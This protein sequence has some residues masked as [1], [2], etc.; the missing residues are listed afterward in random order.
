MATP[1][2]AETT[3]KITHDVQVRGLTVQSDVPLRLTGLFNALFEDCTF[4]ADGTRSG[5]NGGMSPNT[6]RDVTFNRCVFKFFNGLNFWELPERSSFYINFTD[7]KFTGTNST[8]GEYASHWVLEGNS[9][10][11][12]PVPG[13]SIGIGL[14][15][16]DCAFVDNNVRCAAITGAGGAVIADNFGLSYQDNQ[17]VKIIGNTIISN[18]SNMIQCG[19]PD[20]IVAN[21]N[22][23]GGY[24]YL[25]VTASKNIISGNYID[26]DV[27]AL[28]I[29]CHSS[30]PANM[31]IT[32]NTII[33]P[34]SV[35][36]TCIQVDNP[37]GTTGK[38]TIAD[39]VIIGFT[40]PIIAP[41]SE[42][43]NFQL[44]NQS[45]NR[46]SSQLQL[47]VDPT[48]DWQISTAGK[49][50]TALASGVIVLGNGQGLM[51]ISDDTS[52]MAIFLMSAGGAVIKIAGDATYVVGAPGAGQVGI[53]YNGSR[54]TVTNGYV[55][56]RIFS[57]MLFRP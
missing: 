26:T 42:D 49:T 29:L 56:T 9:F 54:Y 5:G 12:S 2:I 41:I 31:I 14:N 30:D 35:G 38:A 21:N 18:N 40:T 20:T 36:T 44:L 33:S 39:N 10:D 55:V 47:T 50:V 19:H 46:L 52:R 37:G 4:I 13:S 45:V 48:V 22:I 16:L 11:L 1:K 53:S 23:V 57:I 27:S 43:P 8:F 28:G 25:N 6:L 24:L 17:Q 32:S 34:T 15:C 51:I 3:T 7:C